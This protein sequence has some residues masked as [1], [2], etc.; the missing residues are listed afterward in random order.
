MLYLGAV[1]VVTGEVRAL[2]DEINTDLGIKAPMFAIWTFR[3]YLL[4]CP[5]PGR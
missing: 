5:Y 1:V 3:L 4:Q 2:I